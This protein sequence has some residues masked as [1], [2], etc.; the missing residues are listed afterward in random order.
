MSAPPQPEESTPEPQESM[1]QLLGTY[2][3]YPHLRRGD[4][5]DGTIVGFTREGVLVDLGAKT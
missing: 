1:A 4:I 2:T 5:V 3:A